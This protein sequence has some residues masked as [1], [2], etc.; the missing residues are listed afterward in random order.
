MLSFWNGPAVGFFSSPIVLRSG[1]AEGK[2]AA[3][4][5]VWNPLDAGVARACLGCVAAERGSQE[6][7]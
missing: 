1:V 3:G 2:P 6:A 7:R 5:N 4:P